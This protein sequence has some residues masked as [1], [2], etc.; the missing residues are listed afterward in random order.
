MSDVFK[1]VLDFIQDTQN[2]LI[3]YS[4]DFNTRLY[5]NPRVDSAIMELLKNKKHVSM[6]YEIP[7]G[8]E[9]ILGF[10][11]SQYPDYFSYSKT[12]DHTELPDVII[13]DDS[14]MLIFRDLDNP[15]QENSVDRIRSAKAIIQS[16]KKQ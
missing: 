10:I 15:Y 4:K 11:Q 5:L 6:N 8:T 2:E 12:K 3:I 9:K 1:K 13:K 16:I 14:G 7:E